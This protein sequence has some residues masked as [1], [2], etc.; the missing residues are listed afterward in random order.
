LRPETLALTGRYS[1]NSAVGV[2]HTACFSSKFCACL[3]RLV[4]SSAA[5]LVRL[6]LGGGFGLQFRENWP[7]AGPVSP[8]WTR[9][10]ALLG[11][12]VS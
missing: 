11:S 5:V 9:A 4:S 7:A 10:G 12:S 6:T 2:G 8:A 1:Y 3:G